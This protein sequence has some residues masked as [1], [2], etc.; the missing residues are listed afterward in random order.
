[1]IFFYFTN[2][3]LHLLFSAASNRNSASSPMK[4]IV[5]FGERKKK[6]CILIAKG[7]YVYQF[8]IWINSSD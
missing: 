8:S 2:Q 6:K 1:V 3:V 5:T 7:D 4:K